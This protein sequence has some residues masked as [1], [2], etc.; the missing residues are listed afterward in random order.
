MKLIFTASYFAFP[1]Y[2]AMRRREIIFSNDNRLTGSWH[3]ATARS[4][5]NQS[6]KNPERQ[7]VVKQASGL[8]PVARGSLFL[9]KHMLV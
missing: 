2:Y 9:E 4:T 5:A 6:H 8:E 3:S 7:S 1:P